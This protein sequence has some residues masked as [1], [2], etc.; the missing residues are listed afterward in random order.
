MRFFSQFP[1][2]SYATNLNDSRSM[3]DIF[4]Y[5]DVKNLLNLDD[6]TS[7]LYYEIVDG[8]RPDVVSSKL[9]GTPDYHWTFFILNEELKNGL[10][11]WPKTYDEFKKYIQ[12]KYGDYSVLE[13]IPSQS[14][15]VNG[16]KYS[17]YF[18]G[19]DVADSNVKIKVQSTSIDAE[20]VAY[21]DERLQLW[22]QNVSSEEFFSDSELNYTIHY[23][24]SNIAE[25]NEWLSNYALPWVKQYHPDVYLNL[26]NDVRILEDNIL[27]FLRG[28]L[29]HT[30]FDIPAT[31]FTLGTIESDAGD[32]NLSNDFTRGVSFDFANDSVI[33]LLDS[34]YL[35][36]IA[37]TTSR[38]YVQ[39]YDA[40]NKYNN[41]DTAY[42][43]LTSNAIDDNYESYYQGESRENDDKRSIRV[44]RKGDVSSF[45]QTY[46]SLI[47]E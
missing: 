14:N 8:E 36:N 17:N 20:I 43:A 2:T 33:G 3:V 4:R 30:E 15:V 21:D 41:N 10:K 45:A 13:F 42:D 31:E 26:I 39:S 12:R 46:K 22:V 25:K 27:P 44:L 35:N 47:N 1:K 5:V 16:L 40:P 9:Y 32:G 28:S 23:D 18:G 6:I 7:H 19:L 11:S 34:D 38:S 29:V 24:S 37:F